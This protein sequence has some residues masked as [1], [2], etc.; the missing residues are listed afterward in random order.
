[1]ALTLVSSPHRPHTPDYGFSS[2]D[3]IA[4]TCWMQRADGHGYRRMLIER[5]S[6][7]EGPAAGGYVLIYAPGSQWA[8]W[9]LARTAGAIVVWRCSDGADLGRFA[10]MMSALEQLPPVSAPVLQAPRARNGATRKIEGV[11]KP[12]RGVP[13]FSRGQPR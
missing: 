10:S 7:D 6:G 4:L 11:P 12:L 8:T 9:G 1:M 5:G 3:L 2:Q 13:R